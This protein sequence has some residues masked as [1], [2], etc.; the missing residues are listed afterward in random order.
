[1]IL[2]VGLPVG[3]VELA[4][5]SSGQMYIGLHTTRRL[6]QCGEADLLQETGISHSV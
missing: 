5:D 3:S 4:Q 6:C 1:M 2:P